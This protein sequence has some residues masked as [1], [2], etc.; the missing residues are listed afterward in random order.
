MLCR[1]FNT[2]GSRGHTYHVGR[3]YPTSL[4]GSNFVE[5]GVSLSFPRSFMQGV[6]TWARWKNP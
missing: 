1:L 6:P 2:A 4:T 3:G 5:I